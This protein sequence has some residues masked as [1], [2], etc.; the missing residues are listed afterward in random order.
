MSGLCVIYILIPLLTVA[1]ATNFISRKLT[2]KPEVDNTKSNSKLLG[3]YNTY[4]LIEC[5]MKCQKDCG[6]L[7]G[8][9]PLLLKCRIHQT[10]FTSGISNE[11]EWTYYVLPFDC[12]NILDIGYN[13]SGVFDIYP[14]CSSPGATSAYCDMQTM[15][16]GWTAIQKRLDG[17]VSFKRTWAEYRTGFGVPEADV[18]IGND[19]IHQLTNGRPSYLYIWIT[20]DDGRNLYELY[21][22]F[23]VSSEAEKYK[24]FLSGLATGTLGNEI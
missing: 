16:G 14:S 21:D 9:N 11:D 1:Q 22:Q 10:I 20:L 7:F 17:A 2:A 18:W 19:V 5:A 12:K 23:S 4:T 3:Q 24:L 15:D 13:N 8:Y 6:H